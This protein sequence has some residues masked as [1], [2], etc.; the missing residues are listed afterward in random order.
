MRRAG[1]PLG[2]GGVLLLLVLSVVFKQDLFQVLGAGGGAAPPAGDGSLPMPPQ[3][4]T[5]EE[6]Q[7]VQFVSFVLDDAQAT[8]TQVLPTIGAQ[9][10]NAKLVLFRDAVESNCGFAEAAMGPFYC[11]LDQKLYIDLAFYD[12]LRQRFGAPGDFAQAYVIAHEI[13]HHVQNLLGIQ[14]KV[15][16]AQQADPGVA[17]ELSVRLELQADCFA[18]VWGHAAAQRGVLEPGD[19]EEG[20]G[21]AAAIG[22]DRMMKRAGQHV[23]PD[24]F[25]HGSS[26][27]RVEWLRRGLQS[28]RC[29]DC[30]TFA[31][32]VQ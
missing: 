30:D 22:D 14:G 7:L 19:L 2:I 31:G 20:L 3:Q 18:G 9:Y 24:A 21:A 10:Q 12:D 11:A 4:T 29:E 17:N 25:T 13:G 32:D 23:V 6:E 28:G 1:A 5:A 15:R 8:W 16:E 26:A 27:Q